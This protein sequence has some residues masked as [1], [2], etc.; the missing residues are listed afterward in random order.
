MKKIL[1]FCLLLTIGTM[2][3][4]QGLVF[5]PE[6]P[7]PGDVITISYDKKG[8]PLE[9]ENKME[10]IAYICQE[11]GLPTAIN[12][13]LKAAGDTYTGSLPTATDSRSVFILFK[14]A[15][16]QELL[17][18]NMDKGY[19]VKLYT[20]D[21]SAVSQGTYASLA[22]AY[23]S[24]GSL[25]E[26]QRDP[27]KGIKYFQKEISAYPTSK[28][29]SAILGSYANMAQRS[30]DEAAIADVKTILTALKAK[31]R[32]TEKEGMLAYSVSKILK[33]EVG[34]EAIAKK[35]RKKY[36]KGELVQSDAQKAFEGEEDLAVKEQKFKTFQQ[37][38]ASVEDIDK[39]LG[40]MAR[41]LASAYGAKG[42][43]DK[44]QQYL[45]FVTGPSQKAG[46]L[47][48]FA[49]NLSGAA[50]DKEAPDI[51]MAKK[52]SKQS[53]DLLEAE[54][55]DLT[56]NKPSYL[57]TDQWKK[58][59]ESS[60]FM[61]A[62][63]YALILYK[64]G[65]KEEAYAYQYKVCNSGGYVGGEMYERLAIFMEDVKGGTETEGFLADKIRSNDATGAMKKQHRRLFLA[66]NT[67]EQAY[68][69]HLAGLEK[70]AAVKFKEELVAKMI[71]EDAPDFRLVNLEGK[72]VSL[73][74]M[75]GKVV[76]LDF[77]ATWCGPCKASFPGMQ[78][79]VNQYKDSD[80][81]V[82][83]FIDTWERGKNKEKDVTD[84]ISKN[85]Y[86]FNVLMD[87][88]DKI[89]AKY[90]VEGIPT[91]FVL[92]GNGKIRFKSVGYSGNNEALVTE[93]NLMIELAGGKQIEK[94][95][96]ADD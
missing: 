19:K 90:K 29:N 95:T 24:Y 6:K 30:N 73:D 28:F 60:F 96:K 22:G 62:D 35:M 58:R 21:K 3:T 16:N 15:D 54:Q 94:L 12:I 11:A 76:V 63:T 50:L 49:W 87:K 23:G 88:E 55:V 5:S 86:T 75:K 74:D 57:T 17:D 20:A 43:W 36:R 44:F 61:Y 81:V 2:A 91:K 66:N 34:A 33:D 7:S 70:E 45:V 13:E 64:K 46:M 93:M 39:V 53:L 71:E 80:Q 37:K 82:F 41:R 47:N 48:N 51:N 26:L 85:E 89:V 40:N 14:S 4:G 84:F 18:N 92:D 42:E 65:E 10:A 77:W 83:L 32:S 79:M 69:K 67:I 56:A 38:Y 8:T 68:N 27:A 25:M 78:K 1:S 72:E 59:L 52:L 31:R 9:D